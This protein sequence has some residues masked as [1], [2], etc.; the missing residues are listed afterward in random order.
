MRAYLASVVTVALLGCPGGS[1]PWDEPP[2]T[3]E[4]VL[5]GVISTDA[6]EWRLAVSPDRKTVYFPRSE[7]FF[8]ATRQATIMVSHWTGNGWSAPTVAP[9]SGRYPDMD[10]F[11]SP[12][13]RTLHF[14][15][16]RPVNGQERTDA[17][18]WRVRRTPDGRWGEPEHLGP[19]NSPADEL[20]SSVAADGTLYFASERAGGLG[21]WDIYRAR[22][23]PGGG[24]GPA[25]NLGAPV[26]TAGWEF[27]PTITADNRLLLFTGL[28][29][30]GGAGN[31]DIWA[32][33][34]VAD[35]WS[36]PSG[37]GSV[38]NTAAD[39]YHPSLSPN[40]DRLFYVV[41]GDIHQVAF[42]ALE[43]PR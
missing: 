3:P 17:D 6:Y 21:G 42:D 31:G 35:G 26:N 32:S 20:Y 9:F 24:Y 23:R 41:D 14:S 30:S 40:Q 33:R 36:R 11:L 12:D 10:P 43:L 34:R 39:E 38:V 7:G 22:P 5:P 8:P 19:V 15:S 27:N 29:R 13:G 18:L 4:P 28:D 1:G 2:G 25:E 37:V 16:I